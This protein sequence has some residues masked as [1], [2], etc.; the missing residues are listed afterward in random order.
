MKT[1]YAFESEIEKGLT[2]FLTKYPPKEKIERG[3]WKKLR[4]EINDLFANMFEIFPNYENVSIQEF[5]TFTDDGTKINL[6]WYKKRDSKSKSAIVYVHG[7]GRIAGSIDMYKPLLKHYTHLSDVPFL[8]I[9][10]RLAPEVQGATQSEDVFSGLLWLK[11]HASE[12]GIDENRIAIM[13]DSGGGGIAAG[14][15]IL[16]RDRKIPVAQQILI[17]PMLDNR[18]MITDEK[19]LPFVL[20]NYDMN[21]TDWKATLGDKMED[22]FVNPIAAPSHLVDF[23]NLAPTYIEVGFLDIFRTENIAYANELSKVG[24][25]V[26]LHVHPGAPHAFEF[27]APNSPI[28]KRAMDDRIRVIK[29]I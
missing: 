23:K 17:Y 25:P 11:K 22:D 2:N 3:D 10:Y 15:A 16:A 18:N 5:E 12:L 24:V 7:G 20:V 6:H 1:T 19:L 29:S 8:S 26:E 21:Y 27:I 13:G 28:S 14:T 9:E 4:N